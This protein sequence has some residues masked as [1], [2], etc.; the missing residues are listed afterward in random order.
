MGTRPPRAEQAEQWG[1]MDPG[2]VATG[3]VATGA[4]RGG[5]ITG[6]LIRAG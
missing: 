1:A 3:A 4:V 2:A 6:T 5:E